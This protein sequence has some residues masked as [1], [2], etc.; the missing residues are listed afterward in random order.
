MPAEHEKYPRR[1]DGKCKSK[2]KHRV[3]YA[4]YSAVVSPRRLL[5]YLGN[6]QPGYRGEQHLRVEYHRESHSV[7][8]SVLFERTLASA[9]ETAQS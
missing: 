2:A 3:G 9:A 7:Q 6:E 4:L 5:R 8:D 1:S